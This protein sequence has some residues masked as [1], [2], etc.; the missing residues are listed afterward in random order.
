MSTTTTRN[1][2]VVRKWLAAGRFLPK[3]AAIT[4]LVNACK[5]LGLS[6]KQR[7]CQEHLRYGV[8]YAARQ[9]RESFAMLIP[10]LGDITGKTGME[11]GPGDNLGVAYC[12]LANGASRV[13]CIEQ[14]LTVQRNA[15]LLAA[16]Y[17]GLDHP[18][19]EL[20]LAPF[21]TILGPQVDFI[22]SVDVLEHVQS[23][24]NA[25][26]HMAKLL[27]PGGLCVH[28]V[29][30][31]GHNAYEG[32]QI[33]M[34]TCPDWAWNLMHS[35]LVTTNRVRFE[36]LVEAGRAVGLRLVNA[37]PT[38]VADESY[39]ERLRPR[40]LPRYASL[41]IEDLRVLQATVAFVK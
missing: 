11:I 15:E 25:M 23:V 27:K 41:P 35:H 18:E 17:D 31:S 26:H 8:E 7:G 24:A 32:T 5:R 6:R 1:N 22:Y 19:P 29:D 21:E 33:D 16:I 37:V 39:V 36:E 12:C 13:I 4:I 20:L 2:Q 9:S 10:F 34:L 38:R 3:R 28:S 40:M 30:F 14:Y